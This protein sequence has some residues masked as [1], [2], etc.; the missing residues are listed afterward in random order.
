[1]EISRE[2]NEPNV[3]LTFGKTRVRARRGLAIIAVLNPPP[4]A[5]K[6]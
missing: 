2:K 6:R 1:M 5:F 4:A 3:F